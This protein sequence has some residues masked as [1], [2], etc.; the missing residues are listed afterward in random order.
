MCGN[1]FENL[2]NTVITEDIT[3]RHYIPLGV[4]EDISNKSKWIGGQLPILIARN[5]H[6]KN[7]VDVYVVL[8]AFTDVVAPRVKK[9]LSKFT[10]N[11]NTPILIKKKPGIYD[12]YVVGTPVFSSPYQTVDMDHAIINMFANDPTKIRTVYKQNP[13]SGAWTL[14][15]L[16]TYQPK[17]VKNEQA[18]REYIRRLNYNA[19]S[20]AQTSTIDVSPIQPTES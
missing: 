17:N 16:S 14:Y 11:G 18:W 13:K 20:G 1:L 15:P 9:M 5:R 6:G 2:L 7:S 19:H 10:V 8:K 12:L 3:K 4:E